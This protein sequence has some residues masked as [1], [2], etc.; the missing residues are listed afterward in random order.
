MADIRMDICEC[1]AK[2]DFQISSTFTPEQRVCKNC[3][4]IHYVEDPPL[5]WER[6]KGS[7]EK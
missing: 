6:L 2:L 1:G 4:K 5:D 7:N 3:G